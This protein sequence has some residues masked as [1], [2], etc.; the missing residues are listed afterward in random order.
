MLHSTCRRTLVR[1]VPALLIAPLATLASCGGGGGG[2]SSA[3][4][5]ADAI[6]LS[7]PP[8]HCLTDQ[9]GFE[10]L[11]TTARPRHIA[12][13]EANGIPGA[14]G[15]GFNHWNVAV[16]LSAPTTDFAIDALDGTSQVLSQEAT[17]IEFAPVPEGAQDLDFDPARNQLLTCEIT[18]RSG[19][20]GLD[21][22]S[23]RPIF[24]SGPQRGA[25][26]GFPQLI[27]AVAVDAA[28]DRAFVVGEIPDDVL[29]VNLRDGDR[30]VVSDFF[31]A[32]VD[33][34]SP[35][36]L[37]LDA[38]RARL[39][40]A[41]LGLDAVVAVDIATGTRSI[42]SDATH[43]TG[44][45]LGNPERI[46]VVAGLDVA[47]V[48]TRDSDDLIG[49]NLANGNRSVVSGA[50]RGA[51]P[52]LLNPRTVAFDELHG[53][54][55]VANGDTSILSVDLVTGD[56]ALL[57]SETH[58]TG[59]SLAGLEDLIVLPSKFLA[60][61]VAGQR[62]I[63]QVDPGTGDRTDLETLRVGAGARITHV[64]EIAADAGADDY[65]VLETD[66]KAVS[67]RS[68]DPRTGDRTL[69]S[70][71]DR[72]TGPAIVNPQSL[73]IVT[74]R[75]QAFV[76]DFNVKALV[77][78]DLAS[79]D[80]TIVSDATHGAGIDFSIPTAVAVDDAQ[81]L[82]F[83]ADLAASDLVLIGVDLATGNRTEFSGPDRGSGPLSSLVFHVAIERSGES[84][85][86]LD[87]GVDNDLIRVDL[88][89]GDRSIVSGAGVGTGPDLGVVFGGL[90]LSADAKSVLLADRDL[91][92]VAIDLAT[93]D[94][95]VVVP[96]DAAL[97]P[98]FSKIGP[99]SR[100]GEEH[101]FALHEGG[102]ALVEIDRA[103]GNRV[104]VSR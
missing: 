79:G 34:S 16:A 28:H 36:D 94:R 2:G 3:A 47:L 12:R 14:T 6:A 19:L 101:F 70:S 54:A 77:A 48:I 59:P 39:V 5:P 89:T 43:G 41:D 24:V 51:G 64:V 17:S 67:L 33:F 81:G 84:V 18:N 22:A 93:G 10:L 1:A 35:R 72:G 25:G 66:F 78:I 45:A 37:A 61:A 62:T 9:I 44:P 98:G 20:I 80:R 7:F 100:F 50:T 11:G 49:V 104:V 96:S 15:D 65:F 87:D 82:A 102:G 63:L 13:I 73:A 88:A 29:A 76:P 42:L 23:G 38:G 74:R 32:G 21:L 83:V 55:L 97:G 40:V 26:P 57:A 90:A 52:A 30:T 31:S 60:V 69:V 85:L 75:G 4:A 8:P 95:S 53:Q 92:I 103:S 99:F 68:V 86:L 27:S 58:G 71:P 46:V 91:G 56:R